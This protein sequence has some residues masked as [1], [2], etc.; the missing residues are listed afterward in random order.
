M[1]FISDAGRARLEK[2]L[3]WL[4][5]G[6]PEAPVVTLTGSELPPVVAFDMSNG[7][8]AKRADPRCGT[9]CCIA[10]AVCQFNQPYNLRHRTTASYWAVDGVHD[11][12][13][14]LLGISA[15]DADGMFTPDSDEVQWSSITPEVAAN[16]LRAY[17]A[18][19]V[20]DWVAAGAKEPE[21]ELEDE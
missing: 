2:V 6:A 16:M 10:G 18:S 9:V 7:V 20:I 1:S 17:L 4:D 13:K 12:A 8:A 3:Q 19:G 14:G 5:E 21:E 11:R 15:E